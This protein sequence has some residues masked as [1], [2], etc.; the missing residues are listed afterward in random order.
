M[1]PCSLILISIPMFMCV[2][3]RITI[4]VCILM[5]ICVL[6]STGM[7]ELSC[8]LLIHMYTHVYRFVNDSNCTHIAMH[9]HG[10]I[11]YLD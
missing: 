10:H 7:F 5:F 9:S 4:A 2:P 8:I 6:M 11:C 3:V 1:L